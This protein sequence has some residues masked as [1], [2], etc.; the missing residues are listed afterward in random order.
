MLRATIYLETLGK[1]GL[2]EFAWHN[3]QKAAYAREK[4]SALPGVKLRFSGR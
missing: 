1:E 3:L 2:R 4:L